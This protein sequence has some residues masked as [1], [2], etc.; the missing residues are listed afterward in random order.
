MGNFRP[1][2]AVQLITVLIFF[3]LKQL[4]PMLAEALPNPVFEIFLYSFPNFAEGVVGFLIVAMLLTMITA[5]GGKAARLLTFHRIC[6]GAFLAAAIY[7]IAQ[8]VGLHD[9]GGAQVY[10]PYDVGFSIAGLLVGLA[11]FVRLAPK[12]SI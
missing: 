3:V 11:V 12:R 1:I 9:L 5:N 8:E 6:I 2:I 10:D 7:V 4:R